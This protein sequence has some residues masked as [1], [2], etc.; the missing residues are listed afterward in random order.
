MIT[1][2]QRVSLNRTATTSATFLAAGALILGLV[3]PANA[4]DEPSV[5]VGSALL[6]VTTDSSS[7]ATDV[8][9]DVAQVATDSSG[10]TAIDATVG[11]VD[12][13]VPTY[14]SNP[15]SLESSTGNVISIELPFADAAANAAVVTEGVVAYDNNN[16]STT[17]P[18][19][20]DDG[21]LQVT[22][23]IEDASAPSEY[24]YQLSIP[25]GATASLGEDGNV[26]I[27]DAE[28]LFVGGVTPA[29]AKD[30]NGVEVPTHYVLSESTLTQVVE[31]TGAEFAYPVV[32]DPW[33]GLA[34]VQRTAWSGNTLQVYP[35]DWAR[36]SYTNLFK[37]SAGW[38]AR[39]AGWDE[40]VSKT[41]GNRENTASM[42]D[43]Y[44]CHF[45]FVRF[46]APNKTSWNL[47]VTRPYV[48][49]ATLVWR[50]CNA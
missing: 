24:A 45:D 35:T 12:I 43:Q 42:R 7:P 15:V 14:P 47:D 23:V 1:T 4:E 33:L 38:G 50:Q 17:A 11:G 40:V 8:L 21:S 44:Y 2:E 16:A 18:V 41:P 10:D 19:V 39:W 36:I 28:G 29:W 34:L 37:V 31:H 9:S 32:A 46:R 48:D 25:A 27:L 20:K 3:V 26:I 6:D 13:T 5:D 22:T 49:Y 30:A